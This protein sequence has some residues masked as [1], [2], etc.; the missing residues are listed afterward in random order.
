MS[1]S[2][3]EPED[4]DLLPGSAG[5]RRLRLR[6]WVSLHRWPLTGVVLIV[7]SGMAFS[8]LW[9]SIFGHSSEWFIPRDI[10]DTF[11]AAQYVAWNGEGL[12]YANGTHL[13]S[14]PGIAVVL[15]PVAYLCNALHL[16]D[17]FLWITPK[18]TAWLLLGPADLLAGGV[19]LLPLDDLARFL[20]ASQRNRFW[21]VWLESAVIW[22]VVAYWGHPEDTLALA[23]ATYGLLAA[24]KKNWWGVGLCF[25]AALLIQPLVILILPI[26]FAFFPVR[27][28]PSLAGLIALPSILLLLPPLIQRWSAT[29]Y[30]II[31]QPNYPAV[32]HS[33]PWLY[34]APVLQTRHLSFQRTLAYVLNP[35]GGV[36][37]TYVMKKTHLPLIVMA[38]P[39]RIVAM[40]VACFIGLWIMRTRPSAIRVVWAAALALSLRCA[41][42]SVVT[43]YYF[44]PGL[45]L[46]LVVASRARRWRFWAA[47]VAVAMCSWLSY[48][49]LAPWPYYA[50]T[51]IPLALALIWS[52]PNTDA[53]NVERDISRDPD[54]VEKLC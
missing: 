4:A 28:W 50:V 52:W 24:L 47:I 10:W 34:L 22:Q 39:G 45:L 53:T 27:R 31:K 7:V 49:R 33:T 29:T 30:A 21:L 15:S 5:G 35:T 51:M 36:K 32:N 8:F 25:A 54:S 41:F 23:F 40:V 12:I 9:Q 11:R 38:G 26:A 14:F 18:P 20:G 2:T 19:L 43:P 42:E 44:M 48:F 17:N 3:S 6:Q 13:V 46:I 16:T 37:I 1:Y